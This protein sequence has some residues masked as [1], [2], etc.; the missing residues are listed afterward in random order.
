MSATFDV[1]TDGVGVITL[2]HPP[3]NTLS[4]AVMKS[5]NAAIDALSVCLI[6]PV[7]YSFRQTQQ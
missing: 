5:L 6:S 7:N 4:S 3:V 1:R 2:R